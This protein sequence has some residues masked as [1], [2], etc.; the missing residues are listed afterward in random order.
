MTP[1]KWVR[2]W[3][4][5]MRRVP[6]ELVRTDAPGQVSVLHDGLADMALVRLPIDREGVHAIP[7]Y[8]EQQ[9]VVV[10]KGHAITAADAVSLAE[11]RELGAPVHPFDQQ[12]EDTLEL[13]AAG[14]G[15]IVLPHSV[16]RL[17]ARRDLVAR[18]VTDADPTSIALAWLSDPAPARTDSEQ[19]RVDTFIGI[20]R[21]RTTNSSRR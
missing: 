13:V 8:D 12:V 11:V 20:V 16:A 10:A 5:R 21:G 18:E 2:I 17:H 1:A 15:S 3:E 4:E 19:Y 7:L 9:V 14:V 6:L